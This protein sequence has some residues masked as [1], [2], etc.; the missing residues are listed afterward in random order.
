MMLGHTKNM[1]E[2]KNLMLNRRPM[3]ILL[4][5]VQVPPQQIMLRIFLKMMM[6]WTLM[7]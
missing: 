5:M 3:L 2:R 4:L 6:T 7:S 1:K